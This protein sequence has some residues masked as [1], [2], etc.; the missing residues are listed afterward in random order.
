MKKKSKITVIEK[1][2]LIN[3][4]NLI[5]KLINNTST[6]N[7]AEKKQFNVKNKCILIL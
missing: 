2:K 3:S 7:I 6:T 5:I 4:V 1:I